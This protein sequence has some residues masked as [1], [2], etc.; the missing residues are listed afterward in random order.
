VIIGIVS[1][2]A[3]AGIAGADPA[4]APAPTPAQ[5][6]YTLVWPTQ[7]ILLR[8]RPDFTFA[9][10]AELT[11]VATPQN[12]LGDCK[13]VSVLP[14]KSDTIKARIADRAL[15][16]AATMKLIRP[17]GWTPGPTPEPISVGVSWPAR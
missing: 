2:L 17:A 16:V 15:H 7:E 1:L 12:T 8:F 5:G 14:D 3:A 10:H 11:C 9:M 4:P 13:V 6:D